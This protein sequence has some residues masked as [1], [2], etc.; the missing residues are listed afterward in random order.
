MS[1]VWNRVT[2]HNQQPILDGEPMPFLIRSFG[3][4]NGKPAWE[5]VSTDTVPWATVAT[6]L[7]SEA[8]AKQR[9]Q[10]EIERMANA[11]QNR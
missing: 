11:L 9:V 10:T 6:G 1:I 4:A 3:E 2:P 8:S 7:P 5:V